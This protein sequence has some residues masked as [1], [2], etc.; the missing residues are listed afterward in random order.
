M[1]RDSKLSGILHILLH[2]AEHAAPV[3]SERLA[4]IMRTN[5]VVVRRIMA[6]LRDRGLVQSDRGHGGGWSIARDLADVTLRDVYDAIGAPALFAIG[7]R[8]DN[9]H[10]AVERAVNAAMGTGLRQAEALLLD[11]FSKV[12]LAELSASFHK[13]LP[14]RAHICIEGASH[15]P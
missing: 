8:D 7:N 10:C 11:T 6:G 4:G 2:M 9:P 13:A 14:E 1:T 15:E 12:T 3:T 5:P